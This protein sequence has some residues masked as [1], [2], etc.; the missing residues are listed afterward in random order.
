MGTAFPACTATGS[1]PSTRT[2]AKPGL[3]LHKRAKRNL[4]RL[5][6]ERVGKT[7]GPVR[8]CVQSS[9]NVAQ[10]PGGKLQVGTGRNESGIVVCKQRKAPSANELVERHTSG[11]GEIGRAVGGTIDQRLKERHI[12]CCV[13]IDGISHQRPRGLIEYAARLARCV[14]VRGP[15][16]RSQQFLADFVE[17]TPHAIPG[18]PQHVGRVA[19]GVLR[20]EVTVDAIRTRIAETRV[21]LPRHLM[22]RLAN[23][24]LLGV[25]RGALLEPR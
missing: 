15:I 16:P 12:R 9:I 25:T 14:S 6:G 20:M 24:Q 23:P 8:T 17:L 2:T 10:I 5:D 19:R 4:R 18:A 3:R 21:S 22:Q 1:V 7:R 13:A 11:R